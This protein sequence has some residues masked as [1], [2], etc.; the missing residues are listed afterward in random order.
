MG[1]LLVVRDEALG[2]CLHQEP[3]RAALRIHEGLASTHRELAHGRDAATLEGRF[4]PSK[5]TL[6][7]D[8][9]LT[10]SERAMLMGGAC[11][12]AYGWAPKKG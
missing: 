1:A 12:K 2:T 4:S 3:T 11:A 9:R 10:D 5:Q 7:R 8:P 6:E